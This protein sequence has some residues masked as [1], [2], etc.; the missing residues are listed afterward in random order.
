MKEL[1]EQFKN[2]YLLNRDE[3]L[4][5]IRK[6]ETLKPEFFKAFTPKWWWWRR[7]TVKVLVVTDGG[8][9][10]GTGVVGLSEFLTA[11]NQLQA[12]TWNNYQITLG[13]RSSSPPSLNPLVVNQISSFNF[14]TSVNLNDFD[15][16]WL[17]GINSGSGL[18]Q[19]ELSVVEAYMNGGG[20]LF[21]TGDHGNLGSALCGNIP[22]VKDMRYWTDTPAGA[23]NDANEVSMSGRRRNDTNRPRLGDATS[24]FF[25][26]QSDNIPQTIAVRTFG[27]GMPH[28]LLSISTNVRASGIIDIM[29]DHPHEGECKPETSFTI[30]NVTVPTQ[31]IATSFV[32][33][34]STTGGGSGKAL[35]DPHCFPS[36]AVWDGRLASVGRVVVD[37]TWHHFV[38][39]NLN[40]VGSQGGMGF[41]PN[42]RPGQQSGLATAD[43]NIIRQY[44]MNISLWMSR[45]KSWLCWRRFLWIELLRDSQLIEAS[46]NNPVEKL[47]NISLADL[48]SIGSLAEEI[49]S[50]KLNPSLAREFLV[51]SLETTNPNVA[52]ILNVW[53]PKSKEQ[54]KGYYQPWLNLD[55]ILYTSIGAGF[56][57]L[58]D[59]KSISGEELNEKDLDRV[60]EIFTK[61]MAFGFD[62]SIENLSSNLKNFASEARLKL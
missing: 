42:D 39:V 9:N 54:Q 1:E 3:R 31:I 38:N 48:S 2:M 32:L 5:L 24:L 53:K 10:F 44:F 34:G 56:I 61:G 26:N 36:I 57:A 30:N 16:V 20:G 46:L 29:P 4:D 13:H 45:R 6:L 21:A 49:L 60:T 40:G 37:S 23:S 55:L 52:S 59:D 19:S 14:Q 12:T 11:F 33:G 27:S 7:C 8:L 58:R 50:S 35:T 41:T 47:E 62:K 22:R 17:F 43:F 51:E 18:S 28:P 25:D 15:Q